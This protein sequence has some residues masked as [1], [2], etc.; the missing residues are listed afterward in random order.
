MTVVSCGP[1]NAISLGLPSVTA[2]DQRRGR[3]PKETFY[4]HNKISASLKRSFIEDVDSITVIASIREKETRIPAGKDVSEILVLALMVKRHVLPTDVIEHISRNNANKI[5][6]ICNDGLQTIACAW[7]PAHQSVGLES[8]VILHGEWLETSELS[9]KLS[10]ED[11]DVAW[12]SICSQIEFGSLEGA[13]FDCRLALKIRRE[14]LEDELDTLRERH[15][16]TVQVATRNR[17]FS[18]IQDIKRELSEIDGM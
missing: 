7:R 11:L 4:R 16:R 5:A 1:I 12:D 9:F 15:M 8:S 18:R 13:D 3:L 6:F 2:V 10:G 14:Q 17:L